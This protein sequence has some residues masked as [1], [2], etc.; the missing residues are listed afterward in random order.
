VKF[1]F[2]LT[3][4]IFSQI[5][6]HIVHVVSVRRRLPIV[7]IVPIVLRL[8][9]GSFS[10]NFVR[11]LTQGTRQALR[12]HFEFFGNAVQIASN[13]SQPL[14]IVVIPPLRP[15]RCG[16]DELAF[17]ILACPPKTRPI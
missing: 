8:V 6:K 1:A 11:S 15:L 3:F 2:R 14:G 4:E 13:L 16:F 7:A 9:L 12:V 17:D 10:L 5:L